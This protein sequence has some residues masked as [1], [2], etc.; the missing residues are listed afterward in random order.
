[1]AGRARRFLRAFANDRC[2]GL[3]GGLSRLEEGRP[4]SPPAPPPPPTL[5]PRDGE[6]ERRL[7]AAPPHPSSSSSFPRLALPGGDMRT[8]NGLP[9]YPLRYLRIGEGEPSVTP[10]AF[11][12]FNA[13]FR[14][15]EEEGE[16]PPPRPALSSGEVGGRSKARAAI[17]ERS[18]T[19]DERGFLMVGVSTAPAIAFDIASNPHMMPPPPTRA[20]FCPSPPPS[21]SSSAAIV[22]KLIMVRGVVAA[23]SPST[24][25]PLPPATPIPNATSSCPSCPS[26]PGEW[27]SLDD[28]TDRS[29]RAMRPSLLGT[30]AP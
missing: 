26:C 10:D 17:L 23:L 25:P 30:T 9:T 27:K 29:L 4:P 3:E 16:R 8:C 15:E 21:L 2:R 18:K 22:A 24:P 13:P 1:M 7:S 28:A 14:G 5:P 12:A 6:G 11:N 20:C 19:N